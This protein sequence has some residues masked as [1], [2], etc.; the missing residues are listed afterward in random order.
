MANLTA[1]EIQSMTETIRYGDISSPSS[2]TCP[3]SMEPFRENDQVCRILTCGHM[4]HVA[5][6]HRWFQR[7]SRCPVCRCNLRDP[8]PTPTS[9]PNS[10]STHGI[11]PNELDITNVNVVHNS[12]TNDIDHISFDLSNMSSADFLTRLFQMDY[13]R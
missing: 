12:N 7:N 4:F 3:I 9:T 10:A 6:I 8:T 5:Q 2:E 1:Q 13:N 11:L